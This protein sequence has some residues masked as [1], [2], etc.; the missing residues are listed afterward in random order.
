ME[1]WKNA[2]AALQPQVAEVRRRLGH[3]NE[4][5]RLTVYAHEI[6]SAEN[7]A[8]DRARSEAAFGGVFMETPVE[9]S[10]TGS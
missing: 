5:V 7:R 1:T 6:E 2:D 4:T 10:A 3:A 8:L 9:T